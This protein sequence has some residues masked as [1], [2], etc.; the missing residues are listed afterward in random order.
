MN[1]DDY[2]AKR[3]LEATPEPD[4]SSRSV[5]KTEQKEGLYFVIQEHDAS[6]RHFDFRLAIDGAL[7]SWAMPK[8]PST[9]PRERRLAIP[10]EDHP[11][12]YADFEGVIPEGEYGA[13]RVIVWDRGPCDNITEKN[14]Q[15]QPAAKALEDGHLLV[16]LHG[17]KLRGGYALQRMG[18]G[19]D[20]WLLVKMDDEEADARRNPTST[21]PQSVLSG[22]TIES[23]A[24]GE[25]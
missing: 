14:G 7:K 24:G 19:G 17:Q 5:R 18:G 6:T 13:G 3:D 2:R 16:W 22:K 25:A 11:L 8:G 23:L 9:D 15:T 10:T 4:G 12:A 20:S 1:D 21:E